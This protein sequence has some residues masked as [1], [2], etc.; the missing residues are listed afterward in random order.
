MK[1]F[2]FPFGISIGTVCDLDFSPSGC[3]LSI[4]GGPRRQVLIRDGERL[5]LPSGWSN[6]DFPFVRSLPGQ[7][8]LVVDT[9]FAAGT[10][11][12]AWVLGPD[13]SVQSHFE[14]GSAA[15]EIA[16][17]GGLIAVAYHPISAKAHGHTIQPLQR[18]GI[19][20][21][22][23]TGR[24]VLGLNQE[25]ARFEMSCDNIR[26]MTAISAT[27]II[28]APE[29]LSVRGQD[30]ENPICVYDLASRRP[31]LYSAPSPRPE[32]LSMDGGLIHLASLEGWE[33]QI[34]TFD[35]ATKISQ[36]RGEFLGIFRGLEGGAFLSQLSSSDYVVM[37]PGAPDSTHANQSTPESVSLPG[38]SLV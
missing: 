36:H 14:I 31:T 6:P 5:E 1:V 7:R 20:F 9:S 37:I 4:Q 38:T 34:I 29:R 11:A 32:A 16:V 13:A 24:F 2:E 3:Q 26:C 22:S 21:Y 18:T 28:F 19:A 23:L 30:V 35:P 10:K 8:I 12:N 15:V 25:L 33:D 17:V 27:E